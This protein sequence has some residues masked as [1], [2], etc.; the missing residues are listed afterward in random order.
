MIQNLLIRSASGAVYALVIMLACFSGELGVL[1]LASFLSVVAIQEW[2]QILQPNQSK[3]SLP[4]MIS[5]GLM[6]TVLWSRSQIINAA[7]TTRAS[8]DLIMVVF[9]TILVVWQVFNAR[10]TKPIGLYHNFF[11]LFYVGF[12][13][14]L[15]LKTSFFYGIYEPWI[16]AS[17]FILIWTL[18]SFAY[19][20]G[21]FFG[22]T[23]FFPKISP[24]KTWEGF[25][26]GAVFTFIAAG[27]LGLCIPVFPLWC[28]MGLA[29]VIVFSATVGD[30]FESGIKRAFHI[31]D[32]G[33]FMPGH[34]GILDRIDSLLFA[35]P[36]AYFYLKM[37]EKL[38]V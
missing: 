11:G 10:M 4:N 9:I 1:F 5:V 18:D 33:N 21:V 31:K 30:L 36:M 2:Q 15:L 37:L 17:I 16:L 13:M 14:Y 8:F 29:L 19:L 38:Y 7:P 23:P 12:P 28:W 32:S 25:G 26:G 27:V 34:G 3:S 24:K 35:L 20:T 22:K 6:L